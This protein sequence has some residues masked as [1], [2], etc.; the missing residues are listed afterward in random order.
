[1]YILISHLFHS[2]SISIKLLIP[3]FNYKCAEGQLAIFQTLTISTFDFD[4]TMMFIR[5]L[6]AQQVKDK[7]G[8][9][10]NYRMKYF[11]YYYYQTCSKQK[12]MIF[13]AQGQLL[14][15]PTLYTS[16]GSS[17]ISRSG[18]L[19]EPTQKM[20]RFSCY[21]GCSDALQ[22]CLKFRQVRAASESSSN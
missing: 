11:E 10:P 13:T 22:T 5:I 18:K 12:E 7:I 20:I 3:N 1:M 4:T 9:T 16:L 6:K 14:S 17:F 8:K 2:H 15:V 21:V 19:F